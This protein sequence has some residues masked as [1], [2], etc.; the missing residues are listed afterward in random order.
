MNPP[1]RWPSRLLLY[2][3]THACHTGHAYYVLVFGS[4]RSGGR[5]RR[6]HAFATFVRTWGEGP[7]QPAWSVEA[8]TISWLP[9]RLDIDPTRPLPEPGINLDLHTTLA[10]VLARGERVWLWG[11]FATDPLLH[12]RAVRQAR[13]L[14]GGAVLYRAA[15]HGFPPGRVS[16]AVH[17]VSDLAEEWPRLEVAPS[18]MGEPTGGL[19]ALHLRPWLLQPDEVH[20][21]LEARLGLEDYPITRRNLDL[22]PARRWYAA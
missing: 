1:V 8:Q 12:E 5:L 22:W 7:N 14:A 13:R 3:L 18:A 2:S 10:H 20:P 16:N 21:W 4:G 6:S 9:Q 11:P 17:A 15:D 19:L